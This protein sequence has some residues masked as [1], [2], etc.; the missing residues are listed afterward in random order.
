MREAKMSEVIAFKTIEDKEIEEHR[1]A[2]KLIARLNWITYSEHLEV[3]FTPK[4]AMQ[5]LLPDTNDIDVEY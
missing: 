3:G 2:C 1:K 4:Q 5:L